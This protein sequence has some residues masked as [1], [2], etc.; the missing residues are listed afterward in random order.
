MC[1]VGDCLKTEQVV[2]HQHQKTLLTARRSNRQLEEWSALHLACSAPGTA[3]ALVD[4]GADVFITARGNMSAMHS[5]VR[6]TESPRQNDAKS[7][8]SCQMCRGLR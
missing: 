4:S 2:C 8:R 3:E 5:V 6:L 7:T 1:E